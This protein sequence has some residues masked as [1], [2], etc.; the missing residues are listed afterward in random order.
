M[1]KRTTEDEDHEPQDPAL[2]SKKITVRV[3]E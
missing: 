3:K 1:E 2:M